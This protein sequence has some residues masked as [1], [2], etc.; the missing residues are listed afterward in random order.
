[1]TVNHDNGLVLVQALSIRIHWRTRWVLSWRTAVCLIQV[2]V[3]FWPASRREHTKLW[4]GWELLYLSGVYHFSLPWSRV[5][6]MNSMIMTW[7][8][9]SFEVIRCILHVRQALL[10]R[11]IFTAVLV[12]GCNLIEECHWIVGAHLFY[13]RSLNS[14][15]FC[16][17]CSLDWCPYF[18]ISNLSLKRKGLLIFAIKYILILFRNLFF[19]QQ[20]SWILN[21][22]CRRGH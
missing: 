14:D 3:N 13:N 10:P 15:H 1:M 21:N 17:V 19:H 2:I 4:I 6:A 22:A 8:V 18:K 7:S 20:G 11:K 5:A 9:H 12:I 16:Y